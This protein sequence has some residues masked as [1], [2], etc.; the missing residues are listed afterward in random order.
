MQNVPYWRDCQ[1]RGYTY[2]SAEFFA[3]SDRLV[4]LHQND[5]PDYAGAALTA[6]MMGSI[7]ES[8]RQAGE[9]H[10][11][12]MRSMA[13]IYKANQYNRQPLVIP[14]RRGG[15]VVPYNGVGYVV[16]TRLAP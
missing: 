16:P 4:L 1:A 9:D 2:P 13:E 3:C 10:R 15:A 8:Q 6:G 14:G 11:E 7:L 12:Y 5:P